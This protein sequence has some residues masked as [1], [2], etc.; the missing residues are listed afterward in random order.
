MSLPTGKY[1]ATI[2]PIV[3]IT[4]LTG[5]APP[6]SFSETSVA[7]V[8]KGLL[9][10]VKI[11]YKVGTK[12]KQTRLLCS[13]EKL[14]TCVTELPGKAYGTGIITSARFSVRRRLR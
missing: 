9:G 7:G 12:T 14:D 4:A 10:S 3:G 2:G 1:D 8:R 5:A 6:G 11:S 13:L